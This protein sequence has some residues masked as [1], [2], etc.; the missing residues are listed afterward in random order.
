VTDPAGGSVRQF[1]ARCDGIAGGSG[2]AGVGSRIGVCCALTAA[3]GEPGTSTEG[4]SRAPHSAQNLAAGGCSALH[5]RHR[6]MRAP[7]AK[8]YLASA[9][10]WRPQRGQFT[11]TR[12]G[13]V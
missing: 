3:G 9:G 6:G 4:M 5:C 10:P 2:A 13:V 12:V 8:Q 11:A 1:G 7:H